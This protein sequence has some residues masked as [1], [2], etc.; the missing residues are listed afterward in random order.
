MILE[1]ADAVNLIRSLATTLFT[2]VFL[3][4][5]ALL[6]WQVPAEGQSTAAGVPGEGELL[7]S[8]PFDRLTL[9]DGTVVV[10]DPI[11]PR[12]LPPY[13]PSKKERRRDRSEILEE[14]N[15]IVGQPTKIEMPKIGKDPNPNAIAEDEVKLHL[16][17]GAVREIA[18]TFKVEADEHQENRIF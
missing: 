17:Q 14:G 9:T 7:R 4:A 13:D 15:I 2:T 3:I 18:A 12:P 8:A 5:I 10:V 6:P 1:K 11:S 16:L